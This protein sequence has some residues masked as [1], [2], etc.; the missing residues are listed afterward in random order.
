METK[1]AS[2]EEFWKKGYGNSWESSCWAIPELEVLNNVCSINLSVPLC[3]ILEK[4]EKIIATVH[5]YHQ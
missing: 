5:T 1:K 4:G 2:E 3:H